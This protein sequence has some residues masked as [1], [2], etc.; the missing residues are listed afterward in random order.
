[1]T[2]LATVGV[3]AGLKTASVLL[4]TAY[5]IVRAGRGSGR[6]WDSRRTHFMAFIWRRLFKRQWRR[7]YDT[8]LPTGDFFGKSG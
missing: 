2:L 7:A 6:L 1:M 5:R 8:L 3:D 4:P